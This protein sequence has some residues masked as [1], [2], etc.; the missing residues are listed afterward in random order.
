MKQRLMVENVVKNAVVLILFALVYTQIESYLVNT[1]LAEDKALAGDALVAVS[2]FA[3]IACFGCFTFTY[4][5]INVKSSLQR[6]LAQFTTAT[7]LLVIG[8]SLMFTRVL[9][10]FIMGYF[11]LMDAVFV[12][13]YIACIGFDFWDL[14]RVLNKK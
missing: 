7:F 6:G 11:I 10:S 9:L 5:K 1:E 4:E 14:F 2:L 8:I 12:L 3:V 13:L